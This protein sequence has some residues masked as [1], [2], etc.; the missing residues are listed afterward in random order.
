MSEL[1]G[2]DAQQN[3]E[4]AQAVAQDGAAWEGEAQAGGSAT[5][6]RKRR[7][8]KVLVG[9]LL[10]VLLIAGI[11]V[12]GGGLYARSQLKQMQ[13]IGVNPSEVEQIAF[14]EDVKAAGEAEADPKDLADAKKLIEEARKAGKSVESGLKDAAGKAGDPAEGRAVNFLIIGSDSRISAGDPS[15]WEEDAQRSDVMMILQISE[16]RKHIA[17]MSVPRDTAMVIPG[18]EAEGETKLNHAY[19]YGGLPLLM[20]T[21]NN[22]TGVRIDHAM[23]VD[24]T[25]FVGLTD[26]VGGVTLT[27]KAEGTRTY[28]GAQALAFVRTRKTLPN[29]DLDRVR[30][31]QAWMKAVMAKLLTNEVLGNPSKLKDT[32]DVMSAY[33]ALDSGFTLTELLGLANSM[34]GADLKNIQFV[35]LPIKGKHYNKDGREVFDID[36]GRFVPLAYAFQAGRAWEYICS[37]SLD[38]LD[39]RPVE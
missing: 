1:Y 31:Q 8:P 4:N 29:S 15:K 37:H 22:L 17:V 20:Q 25:T 34:Q 7:W 5:P 27:S 2:A 11:V 14:S 3:A 13:S 16:D 33:T 9:G 24:F 10:A 39:S 21:I 19:M 32:Y 36:Q 18:H 35:T 23:T 30:R 26:I 38:T 6:A 28:N 12:A